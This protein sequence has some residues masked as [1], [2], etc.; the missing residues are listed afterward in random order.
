MTRPS[1][2]A[3]LVAVCLVFG[4]RSEPFPAMEPSVTDAAVP[5][6]LDASASDLRRPQAVRFREAA[7]FSGD[8]IGCRPAVA[9]V[10]GDGHLDIVFARQPGGVA[11]VVGDGRG[12]F[13]PPQATANV[14]PYYLFAANPGKGSM[15]AITFVADDS[16]IATL[17][18]RG[19]GVFSSPVYSP[20]DWAMDL[21]DFDADGNLDAASFALDPANHPQHVGLQ[22]LR[23][24]GDGAFGV[25][26][27]TPPVWIPRVGSAAHGDINGDGL[28][29]VVYA[30]DWS[31]PGAV[32]V[33]FG[34]K[35]WRMPFVAS[36]DIPGDTELVA[37]ADM[38]RD[39]HADVV[40]TDPYE[41]SVQVLLARGNGA[42]GPPAAYAAGQW[43]SGLAI[44]DF[45]DDGALDV[46]VGDV[47]PPG[48]AVLRGDGRGG[49]HAP[50][51]FSLDW[52]PAHIA[53]A[54][55]DEDGVPDL[56][57]ATTNDVRVLIGAPE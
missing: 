52:P 24:G 31:H 38:N 50:L 14:L 47:R 8:A 43:L 25:L 49:L 56:T 15:T 34:A 39:G 53:A 42:L 2:L 29:D 20:F 44:A 28:P 12:A 23:G 37:V 7:R 35:Q 16:P 21:V 30:N 3:G 54:D 11:L 48:L 41:Y 9:D 17:L 36:Y 40:V 27:T 5:I 1:A 19:N 10:N 13:S 22:I 55:F 4:C 51:R 6:T 18:G 32:H 26:A 45:D 57:V 33:L 46:V